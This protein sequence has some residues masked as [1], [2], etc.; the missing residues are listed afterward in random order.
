MKKGMA[1]LLGGVV[2]VLVVNAAQATT[3][4]PRLAPQAAAA[5][6]LGSATQAQ[7]E[8]VRSRRRRSRRYR[9]RSRGSFWPG[10]AFGAVIGGMLAAQPRYYYGGPSSVVRWCM[11]RY[12]SY[13]PRSGTYLG[14]DGRR[15][16]C[17]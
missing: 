12:R 5:A 11:D 15:H 6:K 13:D 9:S 17:P 1:A 16:P 10:A 3:L 8:L 4:I 2:S 14:Y 7:V